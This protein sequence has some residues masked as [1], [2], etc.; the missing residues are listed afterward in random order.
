MP[1]KMITGTRGGILTMTSRP[2]PCLRHRS[3]MAA[4]G[5]CDRSR[6][7]ASWTLSV[8][9]AANP[10]IW[11]NCSSGLRM[12]GSSS[13]TS[14][15]RLMPRVSVKLRPDVSMHQVGA[16]VDGLPLAEVSWVRRRTVT[17]A[18]VALLA[19]A[20]SAWVVATEHRETVRPIAVAPQPEPKWPM[21]PETAH[22]LRDEALRRARVRTAAPAAPPALDLN[23]LESSFKC[24]FLAETPTGTSAKFDCVLESGEVVKVKYGRNPE[25]AAEVAA[26]RLLATL[27]YPADRI[28]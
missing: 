20:A 13:T 23:V 16:C 12:P 7:S 6:S 5:R 14:T 21:S 15:R 18:I 11:R 9:T 10:R 26:T 27:G 17:A 4:S 25:V 3:T 28:S 1:E 8:Q 19:V 22:A 2:E 24:R